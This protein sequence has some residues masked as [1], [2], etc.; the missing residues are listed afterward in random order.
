M[1]LGV[2]VPG[3][4]QI[5]L[6][7]PVNGSTVTTQVRV[8]GTSSTPTAGNWINRVTISVDSTQSYSTNS[9]NFNGL[10]TVTKGTHTI[11][12]QA[13]DNA[14]ATFKSSSSINAASTG[15]GF[16]LSSPAMGTLVSSSVHFSAFA[17]QTTGYAIASTALIVDG[18]TLYT[19]P[20]NTLDTTVT[21]AGGL[22]N[23]VI[24]STDTNGTKNQLPFSI[25]VLAPLA[26][27]TSATL[28]NDTAGTAYSQT[29]TASGGSGTKTWSLSSGALPSGLALSSTGAI[30]G[31][32]NAVG[33][34]Q[35]TA[36]VADSSG[37]ASKQFSLT[38]QSALTPGAIAIT[39]CN[40]PLTVSNQL[41]QLAND[42]SS[43]GTCL[44]V[45]AHDITIDLNGHTLTY[46]TAATNP[47]GQH[48]HGIL[49]IACWDVDVQ[50]NPCMASSSDFINVTIAGN[51]SNPSAKGTIVQGAA[52]AP[53]SHAIRFGQAE[54][55][56]GLVVQGVDIT[57]QAPSSIPIYTNFAQ[58]GASIYNN[59]IHNN[60]TT[61][62]DRQKIQG[63]SVKLD[64]ESA[65]TLPNM[66]H[67]NVITGGAQGAIR[68]T[69]QAGSKIYNNDISLNAT[70]TNDFCIDALGVGME[71]Y[72]NNCHNTQGRGFHLAGDKLSVHNNTINVIERSTN[73]EYGAAISSISRSSN[74]ISIVTSTDLNANV[75]DTM[76]VAGTA[77]LDGTYKI[78]TA[79]SPRNYTLN[80]IGVNL[81][82]GSG[83]NA[84]GCEMEGVYGIQIESDLFPSGTISV[85]SNNVT[86]SAGECPASALKFTTV[87]GTST[88]NV[89]DNV[90]TANRIGATTQPANGVAVQNADLS[91]STISN[92][93]FSTDSDL[94]RVEYDGAKNV[95][96]KN[97]IV[98][99][100]S[101]PSSTWFLTDFQNYA[102]GGVAS[103][104]N[105]LDPTYQGAAGDQSV[106]LPQTSTTQELFEKWTLTLKLMSSTNLPVSG[107]TLTV[108]DATNTVVFTGVSDANGLVQGIATQKHWL[109]TGSIVLTPDTITVTDTKCSPSVD[110][111]TLTAS[112][113][114]LPA[115]GTPIVHVMGACQ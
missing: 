3:F 96:I 28:P 48:R 42:I 31:A 20:S 93:A 5:S 23:V 38:V 88:L 36:K 46:A 85:Y 67:N 90:F 18:V 65:A 95:T 24:Q 56:K 103:N 9:S 75:G 102:G 68:E 82:L 108:K 105:V 112:A 10:L 78:A 15:T 33:S 86:A 50:G 80:S 106:H 64:N 35:F 2:S 43:P 81:S 101:N 26:I 27:T 79:T 39:D 76:V 87:S 111:F 22:R 40:T 12:V 89:H 71:I 98:T 73:M 52:A 47:A 97:G 83:G 55:V 115:P 107:A 51:L 84:S 59:T 16:W 44:S 7:S 110:T 91:S 11:L 109:N 30:A 58:G 113:T 92:N 1:S 54:A 57:V 21:L 37:S 61:I 99:T 100:G 66:I 63:M 77:G 19:T 14:G 41:Y 25:T 13:W 29:L 104:I 8:M 60:V 114:T 6:V 4:A 17:S 94:L 70:Y 72:N 53:F 45:Q 74:V 62:L 49:G 34:Y 32:T 69:N